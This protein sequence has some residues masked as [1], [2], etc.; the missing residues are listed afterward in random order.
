MTSNVRPIY[1]GASRPAFH[2]RQWPLHIVLILA[3]IITVGPF[4]WML[5]TSLKT[6]EES[7]LIPPT[8]LPA[9]WNLDNYRIVV[10][11]FPFPLF[12][13]NTF[14]M[15]AMAIIGQLIICSMAAYAF[16][17][18][19][20]P[21]RNVLFTLCLALLMVPG[22]I[23]LVP[24]YDIMVRLKLTDTVTALWLP[25]IFSAF[26]TFMLRQFFM[27][28]PKSLDEAAKIDGCSY[29]GIYL[30]ILLPL[31]KPALVSL[32]I[33]TALSAFKDLMWPLIVNNSMTKM[34][35]SA[36]LAMLIGE[37]TTYYPQV[38][39]GSALAIWPMILL[40]LLFQR[41]FI[42]GIVMTGIK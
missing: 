14:A 31:I 28:Q 41:Q 6:F 11:K 32:A 9:A 26:G 24:H 25:K 37:H 7:V 38:M 21:G 34:T 33:L 4:L 22:Q 2:N 15:V 42:E 20:F 5:L 12:Y 16:A 30:R 39:A 40:F 8:L 13:L 35:L 1:R 36:G 27:G 17:R 23:F 10:E 3:S 19:E 18:L 29:F